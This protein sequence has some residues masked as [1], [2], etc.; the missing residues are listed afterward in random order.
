[1]PY[2]EPFG[3]ARVQDFQNCFLR[4]GIQSRCG[5]EH[6]FANDWA[7]ASLSV[8]REA[9]FIV[10]RYLLALI[11]QACHLL[12]HVLLM[13]LLVPVVFEPCDVCRGSTL[14][15]LPFEEISYQLRMFRPCPLT[16]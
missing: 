2:P 1:M 10:L 6:H 14:T 7:Q 4:G 9:C 8:T 15:G 11:W 13:L 5:I 12:E 16:F 3:F